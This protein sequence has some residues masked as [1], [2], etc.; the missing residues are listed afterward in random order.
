MADELANRILEMVQTETEFA[1]PCSSRRG[2]ALLVS[3]LQPGNLA[4][5]PGDDPTNFGRELTY[6]PRRYTLGGSVFYLR[7]GYERLVLDELQK[8][9]DPD[10][11][12]SQRRQARRVRQSFG[13]QYFFAPGS[14]IQDAR[15]PD[16]G[17][18]VRSK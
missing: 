17:A 15:P 7:L 13:Q 14:S 4:Q 9:V 6:F 10:A 1:V 12:R 16:L 5:L 8:F 18:A 11:G 3:D 2:R